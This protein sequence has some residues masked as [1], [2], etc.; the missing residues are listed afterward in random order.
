MGHSDRG[1]FSIWTMNLK[2]VYLSQTVKPVVDSESSILFRPYLPRSNAAS[3]E[4]A[5]SVR[6]NCTYHL[7]LGLRCILVLDIKLYCVVSTCD[8]IRDTVIAYALSVR[9]VIEMTR[10]LTQA[11]HPSQLLPSVPALAR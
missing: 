9:P 4:N 1:M 8:G 2:P 6:W 11:T 7:Q 5:C 10:F 3:E